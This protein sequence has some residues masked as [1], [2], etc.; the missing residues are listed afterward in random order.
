MNDWPADDINDLVQQQEDEDRR[1]EVAVRQIMAGF[2]AICDLRGA[3]WACDG[4]AF[5][6]EQH[7]PA[8]ARGHRQR[9]PVYEK[10]RREY[11]A[12]SDGQ[13]TEVLRRYARVGQT[14]KTILKAIRRLQHED[15]ERA[16][17]I[18][19]WRERSTRETDLHLDSGN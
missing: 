17:L 18:K 3:Q 13:K 9:N 12:A 14:E 6:I 1:V 7:R 19:T 10:A 16:A 4:L 8:K 5:V 2:E 11:E 15:R